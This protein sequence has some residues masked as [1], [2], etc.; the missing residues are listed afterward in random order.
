[1]LFKYRSLTDVSGCLFGER[2]KE[3][4]KISL[5]NIGLYKHIVGDLITRGVVMFA[6][7]GFWM[8]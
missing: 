6:L 1:M 5:D 3:G 4:K 2:E 8:T 7:L